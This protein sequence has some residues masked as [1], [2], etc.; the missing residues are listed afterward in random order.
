MNSDIGHYVQE[1]QELHG[2]PFVL[3]LPGN[4]DYHGLRSLLSDH[5]CPAH[6]QVLV[7]LEIL[8]GNDIGYISMQNTS[9]L[10]RVT[11]TT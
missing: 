4:Q 10:V 7:V 11:C 3:T 1:I 2:H 6:Q 8:F 5:L 9:S